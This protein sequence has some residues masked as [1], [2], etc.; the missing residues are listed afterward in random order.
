MPCTSN[1]FGHWKKYL[2]NTDTEDLILP[3]I[4]ATRLLSI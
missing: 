1:M 4:K 2:V 3:S